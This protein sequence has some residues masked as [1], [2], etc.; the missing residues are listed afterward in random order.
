MTCPNCNSDNCPT[1]WGDGGDETA[2]FSAKLAC[3]R[4]RS[5][6]L[7]MERD[8]ARSDARMQRDDCDAFQRIERVTRA[9]RDAALARAT[10][11]EARAAK[12][13][14]DALTVDAELARVEGVARG[15]GAA[16]TRRLDALVGA[17]E[18]TEC[19][20]TTGDGD[21]CEFCMMI[22]ADGEL[23]AAWRALEGV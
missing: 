12:I 2:R 4:A 11:A 9:E 22:N 15:L 16:L 10:A 17:C 1:T 21:F 8:E 5:A 23:L 18:E 6:R 3:E 13:A 7:E 14:T 19:R 20:T